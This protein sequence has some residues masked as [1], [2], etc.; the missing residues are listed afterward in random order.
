MAIEP[1]PLKQKMDVELTKKRVITPRQLGLAVTLVYA[2]LGAL[3]IVIP[4]Y[5]A[6]VPISASLGTSLRDWIYLASSSVMVY[7]LAQFFTRK[8][9]QGDYRVSLDSGESERDMARRLARDRKSVV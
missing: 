2:L 9:I 7:F 5:Q 3:L 8:L 1:G 6:A 4:A